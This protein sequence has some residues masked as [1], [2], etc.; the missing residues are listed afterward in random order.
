[1]KKDSIAKKQVKKPRHRKASAGRK[2]EAVKRG[3]VKQVIGLDLGDKT[4]RYCVLDMEGDVQLE[5]GVA[6]TK[7][8]LGQWAEKMEPSRIALEVGTHSPWVSRLLSSFGH[9]VIVAN[10]RRVRLISQSNEKDDRMDARTL[11]RLAR[12]D[13]ALLYP[14]RHRGERAQEH[15]M[16]IK[17]RAG[18]VEGRTA[19]VN[20][21]RGQAKAFGDRV[22]ACDADQMRQDKLEGLS[23]GVKEALRPVVEV[24]EKMTEQIQRYDRDVTK[25]AREEYPESA[26]LEQVYGVGTLIALTFILTLD[27]A[28]RFENSRDVGCYLGLRPKRKESGERQP[29]LGITR[30]GNVYLRSLLVQA[31]HCIMSPRGPDTTLKRFG[32]KLAGE[33]AADAK[34]K[35]VKS[36]NAKKRAVVAV[37]RKL[38][39]LLHHLWVSGEVYDPQRSGPASMAAS[40]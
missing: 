13:P 25:I 3:E 22:G 37:A 8:G 5:R 9:E 36:K 28:S 35:N 12:V 19:L 23:E 17:A 6:T 39:I 7:R 29:Q 14:I 16:L 32:Q 10:A 1:M 27:D 38:G 26:L 4:S 31:A 34:W 18:L 2:L 15:L 20:Q 21:V 30:E 40:A 33:S 24:I 11:A